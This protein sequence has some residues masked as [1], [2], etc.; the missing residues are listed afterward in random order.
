MELI[1]ELKTEQQTEH[2]GAPELHHTLP[3]GNW[4][5]GV[6]FNGFSSAS[7][8]QRS[9]STA[10]MWSCTHPQTDKHRA[11]CLIYWKKN[12]KLVALQSWEFFWRTLYM[13]NGFRKSDGKHSYHYQTVRC[14]ELGACGVT[15]PSSEIW[16]V[17]HKCY[18]AKTE[19]F[20]SYN[21]VNGGG[22]FCSLRYFPSKFSNMTTLTNMTQYSLSYRIIGTL[23]F[24]TFS[25]LYDPL[26]LSVPTSF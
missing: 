3:S 7:T 12:K 8:P 19:P 6:V 13:H 25:S 15:A 26:K 10:E 22:L 24:L 4:R 21:I 1:N 9:V 2:P 5:A 17:G 20:L 18:N 14:Q 23:D 11:N 16:L